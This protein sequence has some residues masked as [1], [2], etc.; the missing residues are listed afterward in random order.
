MAEDMR[1]R[2]LRVLQSWLEVYLFTEQFICGLEC[3]LIR[4]RKLGEPFESQRLGV[5]DLS[6]LDTTNFVRVT[7]VAECGIS[8]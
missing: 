7:V 6:P 5:S 4:S 8:T 1:Q 2:V 3:T